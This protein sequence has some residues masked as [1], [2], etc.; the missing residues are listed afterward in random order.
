MFV[1]S[2]FRALSKHTLFSWICKFVDPL[3]VVSTCIYCDKY[4]LNFFISRFDAVGGDIYR[5]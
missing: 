3:A 5:L 2:N 1:E 4:S